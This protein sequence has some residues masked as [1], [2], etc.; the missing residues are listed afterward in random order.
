[1][2]DS[3]DVKL[4]YIKLKKARLI[5][6]KNGDEKL[7]KAN[8]IALKKYEEMLTSLPN[9]AEVMLMWNIECLLEDFDITF[10]RTQHNS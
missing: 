6:I 7:E 2:K 9:G 3:D 4:E 5:A 10:C 8:R 1:M